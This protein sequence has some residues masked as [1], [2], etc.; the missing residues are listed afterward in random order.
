LYKV[1]IE[2][3]TI[4]C[5]KLALFVV[6]VLL[7]VSNIRI[8]LLPLLLAFQMFTQHINNKNHTGTTT[9]TKSRDSAV[10]IET[11][12]GLDDRGVRARVPVG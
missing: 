4:F 9:T 6:L 5:P 2:V 7:S 8:S 12:Y 3:F 1:K 10:G 11:G